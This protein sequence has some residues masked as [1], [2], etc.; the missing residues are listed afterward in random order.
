MIYTIEIPDDELAELALAVAERQGWQALVKDEEGNDM[1]NPVTPN[2]LLTAAT[3]N[4]W[5]AELSAW[6]NAKALANVQAANVT[7]TIQ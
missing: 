6:R 2:A 5:N 4:F 7:L 1:P 3:A